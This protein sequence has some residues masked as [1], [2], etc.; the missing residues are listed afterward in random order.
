M[1]AAKV[2]FL[3]L[4][5]KLLFETMWRMAK[6]SPAIF[7]GDRAWILGC[8]YRTCST[9]VQERLCTCRSSLTT[10]PIEWLCRTKSPYLNDIHQLSHGLKE[11][12]RKITGESSGGFWSV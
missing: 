6:S 5:Q 1:S 3:G 10:L 4:T 9:C 11:G 12:H 8:R 7:A 2:N